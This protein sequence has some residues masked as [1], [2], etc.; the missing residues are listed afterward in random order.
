MKNYKDLI[1][2]QKSHRTVLDVYQFTKHFP[3]EE[4]YNLTSQI[5]R[6][7]VSIPTNIAEGSGR[8]SQIDFAH[9]LQISIGSNQELEYLS[10]LALE[11]NYISKE[12]Y[13]SV[14]GNINEVR[15]M[16]IRLH[17]RLRTTGVNNKTQK[18]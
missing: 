15:A 11:L 7:A 13:E 6:A 14:Q 18:K 2:W 8:F 5:R 1:V 9:F 3:K 16:L 17:E 10:F 12:L 4:M